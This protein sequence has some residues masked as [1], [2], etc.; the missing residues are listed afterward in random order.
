MIIITETTDENLS[1]GDLRLPF[2]NLN[3]HESQL[4]DS[5]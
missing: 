4:K 1:N 5:Q 2:Y 3:G